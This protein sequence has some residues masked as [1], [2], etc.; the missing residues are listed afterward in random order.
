MSKP[1]LHLTPSNVFATPESMAALQDYIQLH[2]GI[3][4]S[5]AYTVS[6]MTWNLA[7]KI[8]KEQE[9]RIHD[10]REDSK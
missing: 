3:E 5:V 8:A 4:R 1:L 10:Q 6:G 2:H 7:C 9:Q